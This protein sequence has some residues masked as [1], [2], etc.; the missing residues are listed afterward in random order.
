MHIIS[1]VT[2]TFG[3]IVNHFSAPV[4]SLLRDITETIMTNY[5][6]IELSNYGND[7]L[8]GLFGFAEGGTAQTYITL[9]LILR[10]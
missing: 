1:T 5:I 2:L 4:K 6:D 3:M 9:A 10:R 8:S 7:V